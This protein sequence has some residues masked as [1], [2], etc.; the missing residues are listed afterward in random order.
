[1]AFGARPIADGIWNLGERFVNWYAIE[2]G[3]RLT[4]VDAGL[5]IDGARLAGVLGA[6][7][8]TPADVEAVLLTHAHGDHIG[9]AE[10]AR[11]SGATVYTHREEEPLALG[12][13]GSRG[14]R[15]IGGYLLRSPVAL[16]NLVWLVRRGVTK[17]PRARAVETFG[18]GE[19]LDVPGR[20]RAVH[21]PG[22]T[23]GHTAFF[24]EDRGLLFTGD[25][26][27]TYGIVNSKTGPRIGPG[28]FNEDGAGALASLSHLEETK[29]AVLL[30]G[31]G[32]PW[33]EGIADAARRAR[34]VG[35]W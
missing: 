28:A 21:V 8:R 11:G 34:E 22:H 29:A 19:V 7:G 5:P 26:L 25:A 4:L 15:K 23:P 27:V 2:Q 20:P 31:H 30:P 17:A 24:L 3:G 32:D 6:I 9:C 1:M 13:R 10:V 12:R 35:V 18:D 14:E 33:T 16:P